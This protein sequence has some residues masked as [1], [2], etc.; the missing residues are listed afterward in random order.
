M[1]YFLAGRKLVQMEITEDT[2]EPF[3]RNNENDAYDWVNSM[4]E[5]FPDKYFQ[6]FES[7]TKI[8]IP[9]EQSNL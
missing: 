8:Y 6:Y 2:F 9:K 5:K 1:Y 4:N 7:N 3:T